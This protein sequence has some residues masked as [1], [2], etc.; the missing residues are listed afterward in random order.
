M[1]VSERTFQQLALED[2]EGHWELYCGHLRRKPGMTFAH[3]HAG[4]LL[5]LQLGQQLD[6]HQFDVRTNA[7]H[8]RRSA[9]TTSSPMSSSFLSSSPS[10]CAGGAC[11]NGTMPRCP[12]S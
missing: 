5:T 2:P 3:N 6:L 4:F 9:E 11:S 10:R 1:P 8:V 7:G 12:W